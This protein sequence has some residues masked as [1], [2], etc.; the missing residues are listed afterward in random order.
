MILSPY[1]YDRRNGDS[2]PKSLCVGLKNIMEVEG[3]LLPL[4]DV[5]LKKIEILTEKQ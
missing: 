5:S 3:R 4:Y 2:L 1:S